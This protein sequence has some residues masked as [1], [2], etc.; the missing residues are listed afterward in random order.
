MR[1]RE[2]RPLARF[3]PK[4][5]IE[6]TGS[7]ANSILE[8]IGAPN[9]TDYALNNLSVQQDFL[10]K[11]KN[12][13]RLGWDDGG[14]GPG[15]KHLTE[16]DLKN[17]KFATKQKKDAITYG[18]PIALGNEMYET[19]KV[20]AEKKFRY[21]FTC[22]LLDHP[23]LHDEKRE[24]TPWQKGKPKGSRGI[25]HIGDIGKQICDPANKRKEFQMLVLRLE[26]LGPQNYKEAEVYYR[27]FVLNQNREA[28]YN[29]VLAD[30]EAFDSSFDRKPNNDIGNPNL[31]DAL[32]DPL[33]GGCNDEDRFVTPEYE[34]PEGEP[35]FIP[36]IEVPPAG[37]PHFPPPA[38]GPLIGGETPKEVSGTPPSKTVDKDEVK[39]MDEL[40]D[41]EDTGSAL[42]FTEDDV[43]RIIQERLDKLEE[44]IHDDTAPNEPEPY[45]PEL[46]EKTRDMMDEI[47]QMT[48]Y[49]TQMGIGDE[50]AR[51]ILSAL[52]NGLPDQPE[53]FTKSHFAQLERGAAF[54]HNWIATKLEQIAQDKE[55]DR[56]I[57][58]ELQER[59]RL[60]SIEL[61][62]AEKRFAAEREFLRNRAQQMLDQGRVAGLKE[63]SQATVNALEP[64]AQEILDELRKTQTE[65]DVLAKQSKELIEKQKQ[66]KRITREK[67]RE[68]ARL[69]ELEK[70]QF[71]EN[72]LA[73]KKRTQEKERREEELRNKL[74]AVE[75]QLKLVNSVLDESKKRQEEKSSEQPTVKETSTGNVGPTSEEWLVQQV[76]LMQKML[77][78]PSLEPMEKEAQV[79]R[80][81][82][83]QKHPKKTKKTKTS[84]AF[85]SSPTVTGAKPYT[86]PNATTGLGN[87]TATPAAFPFNP[88]TS[89]T[90]GSFTNGKWVKPG[91]TPSTKV[92]AKTPVPSP[93]V[94]PG[95]ISFTPPA[96]LASS[97]ISSGP[98]RQPAKETQQALDQ[99]NKILDQVQF[100]NKGKPNVFIKD[101]V[102]K[103]IARAKV[104][105]PHIFEYS[106]L[107]ESD[108]RRILTAKLTNR[109]VRSKKTLTFKSD[110]KPAYGANPFNKQ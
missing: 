43:D 75:L 16:Q 107:T 76:A 72:E 53:Q 29:S 101:K 87:T 77:D 50:H 94:K 51:N 89:L 47:S 69:N 12:K 41:D 36:P 21:E 86:A 2:H 26:L 90:I 97:D 15:H 45:D 35:S 80:K 98:T 31:M 96:T 84:D 92:P 33:K 59:D 60:K 57:A 17:K 34:D 66:S 102:D 18:V 42:T 100:S 93:I 106:G 4:E 3:H 95:T 78:I 37:T 44:E 67:E 109:N 62:E 104:K 58:A 83:G 55:K 88:P 46:T 82:T 74:A 70:Q 22:W 10:D 7:F 52:F 5:R 8:Y 108:A 14:L 110:K 32:R 63:G 13:R 105:Y 19:S 103:T 11:E 27:L 40:S 54:I 56:R 38:T 30:W 91:E 68:Q 20:E 99:V 73:E 64:R 71:I 1:R 25:G 39:E 81:P 24:K 23:D 61:E 9:P 65:K 48:N 28:V 6:K 79:K 49:A 85:A